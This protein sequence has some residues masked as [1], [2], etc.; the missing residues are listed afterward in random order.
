MVSDKET[1][2]LKLW[3]KTPSGDKWENALPIGNGRLGAMI[4]GNVDTETV[5]LNEHTLWSGSP[6]RNDHPLNADS[7]AE[8]RNLIFSGKQKEAE[9]MSDRLIVSKKSQG[10]I[11]EPAGELHLAFPGQGVYSHY[12]RELDIENAVAK[13]SYTAD[14]VEYTREAIASFADRVIVIRLTASKPHSISL[15]GFLFNTSPG[16]SR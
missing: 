13:T 2:G 7:L 14:G 5:Q 12:Y 15:M 3:Y 16:S 11:F 9:R 1:D 4:Y 6:N 8:I 10:Q